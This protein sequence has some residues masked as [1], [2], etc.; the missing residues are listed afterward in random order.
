MQPATLATGALVELLQI[1]A[2]P[3]RTR[4]YQ[5]VVDWLAR[6]PRPCGAVLDAA[7]VKAYGWRRLWEQHSQYCNAI[8]TCRRQGND[9]ST[10]IS[11]LMPWLNSAKAMYLWY[12]L[13]FPERTCTPKFHWMVDHLPEYAE[14]M[15]SAGM[16][17][18]QVI[19]SF[20]ASMNI[21]RR[22]YACIQDSEQR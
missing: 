22:F 7:F 5:A 8:N 17:N 21:Y 11:A 16:T 6:Q 15:G 4:N 19:E 18:E 20:H 3:G 2:P 1:S 13:N 9:L 14:M 10:H 12:P